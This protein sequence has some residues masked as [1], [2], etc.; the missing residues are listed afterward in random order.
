MR[1]IVA[2]ATGW[3]G[4]KKWDFR[5]VRQWM[6]KGA[7]RENCHSGKGVDAIPERCLTEH[8]CYIGTGEFSLIGL[9]V[10]DWVSQDGI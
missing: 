9:Q 6:K 2:D 3:A 1:N 4:R 8:S 5:I 10:W 7:G